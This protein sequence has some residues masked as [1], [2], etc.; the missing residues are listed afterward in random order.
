MEIFFD[1]KKID[2]KWQDKWESA[3]LFKT[4][5]QSDKPKYYMLEQFPYPSGKL[6]MGHVRVYSIGDALA[7]F[8]IMKGFHVLHPMGYDAFGLPAENA[9]IN[10]GVHP[11]DWTM[12]CIDMMRDQQK[13]LGLSYDWSREVATCTEDYYKWNQWFFIKMFEKG[14]AYKKKSPI[15][16]CAK[17]GTVLANEQVENGCCW[18]CGEAVTIKNLEQ[19][20]LKITDY[21]QQLLDDL[22]KLDKWPERVKTMQKNWI[23]RSEGTIVNFKIKESGSDLPIFTTRPD[24]LYGVTFMVFAP[25]HPMVMELVKGTDKEAE[26]RKFIDKVVLEDKFSR[27]AEDKEK[28]G[29]YI[30]VD[31]INPL[32]GDVVKIYIA[33]FVLMEYGTG[34]I[35]AVPAHDQRDFEF[36]KKYGIPIKV[37]IHPEGETLNPAEMTKA[38]TEQGILVNSDKFT[39]VRSDESKKAITRYLEQQGIGHATVQFKLRDWLISRQRYWGTPI[40]MIYC[41]ACGIVPVP[42]SELPIVLPKDVKFTGEGNP[43]TTDQSFVNTKCPLCGKDARRETD[44]M[45]TFIDSSWYYLRYCD[46]HNDKMPF[47]KAKADYWMDVDQYVGGIEHAILHLLYSRFFTKALH[48]LGVVS[49]TEPF[50]QLLAQGMVT[51]DGAKMSKSLGN[52]VAP[53]DIIN[54]YGADTARTFILFA[55]PPEKELEWSD[56]GVEGCYRFL[57]RI[58]RY[59]NAN[60]DDILKG[61]KLLEK[62]GLDSSNSDDKNLIQLLHNTIKRVTIDIYERFHFNTA[63]AAIMELLNGVY[64]YNIREDDESKKT[65]A[66]VV[67]SL[68]ILLSPFA[69]HLSE[70]M[71][72]LLGHKGFISA[73]EWINWDEQLLVKDELLIV[74]QINGKVRGKLTVP[75]NADEEEIKK[76]AQQEENVLKYI[77][78]KSIRQMIYVKGKLLN[79]VVG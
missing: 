12:K 54:T 62:S 79:I 50:T 72:E 58:W 53:D 2:K 31:A 73:Q 30:G 25:E 27:T 19:W 52:V 46:P 78:G 65:I 7:R 32:N 16:W 63:I 57:S 4:P 3:Q 59:V 39:D 47:D 51:K 6:H 23:G 5:E 21:A 14:L 1:H 48:D 74:V 42:E 38:Y 20:F 69:P 60:K 17:C 41:D 15:N 36:A 22:D 35:M 10:K 11:R 13:Q 64:S 29:V 68:L 70:E 34:C 26:V 37:V 9:A 66:E 33:N 61:K 8:L 77:E 76:L 49:S 28:E 45:D 56:Q 75:A 43:I 40:P 18:R 67:K 24:T 71:W 55:A 44:T